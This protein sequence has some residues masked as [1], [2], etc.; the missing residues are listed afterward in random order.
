MPPKSPRC[1]LLDEQGGDAALLADLVC[2]LGDDFLVSAFLQIE[3]RLELVGSTLRGLDRYP[4]L[5]PQLGICQPAFFRHPT[6][7]RS[8]VGGYTEGLREK[9]YPAD[10]RKWT[11]A[12]RGSL[13]VGLM[14][15]PS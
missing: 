15:F 2:Q 6:P 13:L 9:L 14:R 8:P 7:G 4:E 3:S 5:L 12:V 11:D 1:H 10:R